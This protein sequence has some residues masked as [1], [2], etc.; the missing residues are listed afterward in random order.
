M[1]NEENMAMA[2]AMARA[3]SASTPLERA[4]E[5]LR[6]AEEHR[7]YL[8]SHGVESTEHGFNG[9]LQRFTQRERNDTN[10]KILEL[11]RRV[12]SLLPPAP[13]GEAVKSKAPSYNN[14]P[15]KERVPRGVNMEWARPPY[16]NKRN[17]NKSRAPLNSNW[18]TNTMNLSRVN[19]SLFSYNTPKAPSYNNAKAMAVPNYNGNKN[20]NN[21]ANKNA[22]KTRATRKNRKNRRST[23]KN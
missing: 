8:Y 2:R 15:V 21:N 18:N 14:K 13:H 7:D 6:N 3:V 20:G 22:N 4:Q 12:A 11:K 9:T 17:A 1:P 10:A 19:S 5:Q 23:R 16:R